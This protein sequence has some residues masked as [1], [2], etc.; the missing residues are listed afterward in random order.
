[1]KNQE[2]E[3]ELLGYKIYKGSLNSD[4]ELFN[5]EKFIINTINAYSYVLAKKDVDFKRALKASNLLLPD[6]FS[7][8]IA[9]RILKGV[10]IRKIAGDDVFKYLLSWADKL[11]LRLFFL[12]SSDS[13][14]L[15]IKHRINSEYSNI[16][17]GLF[18]PPFKE[19][20]DESDNHRII[21]LVNHFKPD[22]L[23][24]GMTA[25]KQEKWVEMNKDKVNATIICSIGAVFDFYAGTIRRPSQ[26]W[27]NLKLEWFIRLLKEP[28]RLWK[29]YLVYSPIFFID[30][31]YEIIKKVGRL[32]KG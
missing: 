32:L 24:V 17:I 18:S 9:A 7:I 6:G 8:Q 28:K 25:P 19:K 15:K 5:E 29:R 26:F 3:V 13:T 4:L 14:L 22:I 16:D 1:M 20:F 10:K 2:R 23:F 11:Q 12:G 30:I 31:L 21:D 27:I